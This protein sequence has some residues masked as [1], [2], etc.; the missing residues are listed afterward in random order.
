MD[1]QDN[2][3]GRHVILSILYI[4]SNT[5]SEFARVHPWLDF[6]FAA[7]R[8]R[9]SIFLSVVSVRSVVPSF[10]SLLARV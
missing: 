10:F 3:D 5:S 4:L 7:S 6:F 1:G 8:L 2:Q 9:V